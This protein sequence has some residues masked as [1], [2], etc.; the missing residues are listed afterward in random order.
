MRVLVG[1]IFQILTVYLS[2]ILREN[3]LYLISNSKRKELLYQ[4]VNERGPETVQVAYNHAGEVDGIQGMGRRSLNK[5]HNYKLRCDV[6]IFRNTRSY[7]T[8]D[9]A[10]SLAFQV[11]KT[12]ALDTD[13]MI[14]AILKKRNPTIYTNYTN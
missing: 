7:E 14:M 12:V 8:D 1:H 10:N 13:T 6:K 11:T 5:K 9:C 4:G 3:G 2:K